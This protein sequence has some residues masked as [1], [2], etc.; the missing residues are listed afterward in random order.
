MELNDIVSFACA[1][2]LSR[3]WGIRSTSVKSYRKLVSLLGIYSI[4]FFSLLFFI[5]LGLRLVGMCKQQGTALPQEV[6]RPQCWSLSTQQ[7]ASHLC[8]LATAH[9]KSCPTG[10]IYLWCQLCRLNKIQQMLL[11][12]S[13]S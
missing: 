13:V 6:A 8:C 2:L 10:D 1:Y 7:M 11:M 9:N 5:G 4:V 12:V 3:I